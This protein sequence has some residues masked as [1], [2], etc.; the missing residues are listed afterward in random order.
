MAESTGS[1]WFPTGSGNRSRPTVNDWFPPTPPLRG[2][3]QWDRSCGNRR[4]DDEKATGS[5]NRSAA[6]VAPFLGAPT[7]LLTLAA[8]LPLGRMFGG[9]AS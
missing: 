1:H 6:D 7:S 3:N 5:G 2:G 8:N 4:C 9:V